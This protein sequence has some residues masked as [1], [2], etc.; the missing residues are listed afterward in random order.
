MVK[1]SKPS[2]DF[3]FDVPVI[4]SATLDAARE[5]NIR[6]IAVEAGKTLLLDREE[7]IARAAKYRISVWGESA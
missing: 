2:Q 1:V 5:A 3:R 7:L 4:G 6:V